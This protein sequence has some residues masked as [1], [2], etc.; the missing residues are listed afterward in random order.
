MQANEAERWCVKCGH[1]N[2][3]PTWQAMESCPACGAI[4]SKALPPKAARVREIKRPA[5]MPM[6]RKLALLGI[7]CVAWVA[8]LVVAVTVLKFLGWDGPGYAPS[9]AREPARS[10]GDEHLSEARYPCKQAIEAAAKYQAR[11]KTFGT[12]MPTGY[13][14]EGRLIIYAGDDVEM[15]NGFGA[16]QRVRYRCTF[17]PASGKATAVVD[18]L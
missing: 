3:A 17:D 8:F 12:M 5:S 14:V 16:W 7:V 13:R 11:F 15:Q 6:A 1:V 4:Y 9:I 18:R 2:P 10:V